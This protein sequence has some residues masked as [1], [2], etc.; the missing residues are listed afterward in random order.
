MDG[1]E[2]FLYPSSTAVQSG[3]RSLRHYGSGTPYIFCRALLVA[4]KA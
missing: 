1:N 3:I 2:F 4:L